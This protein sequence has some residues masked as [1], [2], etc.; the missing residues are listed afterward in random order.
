MDVMAAMYAQYSKKL[1]LSVSVPDI[2]EN[3]RDILYK[4]SS[5]TGVIKGVT[6]VKET[7]HPSFEEPVTVRPSF[8]EPVKEELTIEELIRLTVQFKEP[9]T[10]EELIRVTTQVEEPVKEELIIEPVKK[11]ILNDTVPDVAKT[12][13]DIIN[14]DS[15]PEGIIKGEEKVKIEHPSFEETADEYNAR[16]ERDK[17]RGGIGPYERDRFEEPV[18]EIV[19]KPSSIIPVPMEEIKPVVKDI[20]VQEAKPAFEPVAKPTVDKKPVEINIVDAFVEIVKDIIVPKET[21]TVT[22]VK[23]TPTVTPVLKIEEEPE[24]MDEYTLHPAI[25]DS[26]VDNLNTLR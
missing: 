7:V 3:I 23:E 16:L 15:S 22:A 1:D 24:V 14:I 6:E 11:E 21:P 8:K 10:I 4:D 20:P 25:T 18:E 9:V 19:K 12:V 13:S 26:E 5:P 17:K 2:E